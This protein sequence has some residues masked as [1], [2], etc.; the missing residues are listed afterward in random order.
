MTTYELWWHELLGAYGVRLEEGRV[1]GVCGPIPL[2][3]VDDYDPAQLEYDERPETI[4]RAQDSPE[5]FCLLEAWRKG[6]WVSAAPAAQ[7]GPLRRALAWLYPP[8]RR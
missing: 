3:R 4:L 5:Q 7:R 1:T 6:Q 8:G 2:S